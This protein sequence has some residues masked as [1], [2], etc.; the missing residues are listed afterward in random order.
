MILIYKDGEYTVSAE[1][2]DRTELIKELTLCIHQLSNDDASGDYKAP[3][4]D[5]RV[6]AHEYS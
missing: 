4:F 3:T 6:G 5:S 2:T 1:H